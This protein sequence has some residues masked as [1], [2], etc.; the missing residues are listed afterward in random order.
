MSALIGAAAH[1]TRRDFDWVVSGFTF[2]PELRVVHVVVCRYKQR[3]QFLETGETAEAFDIDSIERNVAPQLLDIA[4][5]YSH[6][7]PCS[8]TSS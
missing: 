7:A 2:G 6:R 1:T 8:T 3:G 4:R 5:R